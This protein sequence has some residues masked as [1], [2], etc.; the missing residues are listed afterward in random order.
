M[1]RKV[2]WSQLSVEIFLLGLPHKVTSETWPNPRVSSFQREFSSAERLASCKTWVSRSPVIARINLETCINYNY[3]NQK[4][5]TAINTLDGLTLGV[6][7]YECSSRSY[8]LSVHSNWS[9]LINQEH[10]VANKVGGTREW[11]SNSLCLINHSHV[12]ILLKL[13]V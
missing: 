5:I 12:C 13:W 4:M 11:C 6:C 10:L 1:K 9:C 2:N 8:V 7:L 3:L